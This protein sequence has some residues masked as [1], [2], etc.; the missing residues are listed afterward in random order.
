MTH[1]SSLESSIKINT[2]LNLVSVHELFEHTQDVF[3][4][5]ARRAFEMFE[6]VDACTETTGKIGSRGIRAPYPREVPPLGVRRK[7]TARAE[8]SWI[9]QAGDQGESRAARLSISGK[10]EP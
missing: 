10:T 4:L 6:P 9:P 2:D 5:I 3:N 7:L 1:H 8:T